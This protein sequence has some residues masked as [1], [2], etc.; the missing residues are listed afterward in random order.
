MYIVFFH[1]R[2][3]KNTIIG[4]EPCS[5]SNRPKTLP[6]SGFSDSKS[7]NNPDCFWSFKKTEVYQMAQERSSDGAENARR[8]REKADSRQTK[9]SK[10]VNPEDHSLDRS[11]DRSKE[12]KEAA[13]EKMTEQRPGAGP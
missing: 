3:L 2:Q 1:V 12:S 9:N 11:V 7:R 13:L 10:N 6:V 8:A 5:L 4:N